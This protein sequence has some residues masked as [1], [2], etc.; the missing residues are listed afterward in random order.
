MKIVGICGS[1]RNDSYTAKAL[2]LALHRVEEQGGEAK[3]LDLRKMQLPFCNGGKYPDFPDV[4]LLRHTVQAADAIVLATPEYHGSIS[5]VLKN[6]LDLIDIEHV[7]GKVVAVIGVVGG[8]HSSGII[9]T[10]R[11]ICRALHMWVLPTELIIPYVDQA[12]D[13]HGQL[14]EPHAVKRLDEMVKMLLESTQKLRGAPVKNGTS[15]KR[16]NHL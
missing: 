11:L 12:F 2:Q 6:A 5:G 9:Q 10:I 13:T 14:I 15:D 16:Q 4:A 8:S 1:L 7:R 3:M